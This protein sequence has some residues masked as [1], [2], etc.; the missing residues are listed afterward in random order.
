[1]MKILI[2]VVGTLGAAALATVIV[3]YNGWID[4]AADSPHGPTVYRLIEFARDRAIARRSEAVKPPD[5][6][7]DPVRLRRGAGNYAAMCAGCHLSPETEDSELRKGLY[8]EP[9]SLAKTATGPSNVDTDP[10]RR[11]WIIKH[12]IKASGMPAWSKG[13]MEDEAI[14]DLVAFVGQLPNLSATEYRELVDTSAGHAHAGI[15]RAPEG[16]NA[17]RDASLHGPR[18]RVEHRDS[19]TR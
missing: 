15:S 3:L 16:S 4:I 5:D 6:L 1:M 2:G 8:P 13:G 12:G 14:W 10:A 7:A 11:F 18:Y 9:P 19:L 17:N